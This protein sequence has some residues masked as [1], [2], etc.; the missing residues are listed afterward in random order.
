LKNTGYVLKLIARWAIFTF[1]ISVLLF[2]TAGTTRLPSLRNYLATF[3]A[4]LLATMLAI[5]PGLAKERSSTFENGGPPPGRFAAGLSFL[6]TLVFAALDVGR[7]EWF[8]SVPVDVRRT[9]LL[10]FAGAMALQMWAMIVNPFFSPEIR[11]QPECDHRLVACGPYRLL[12]HPGY[13]AM[14][15]AVPATALAIGS[16]LAL[17]PATA[18]CL[19]IVKRVGLE[20]EFLQRNLPGYTEYMT[21]VRGRLIPGID[22]R[23]PT[24]RNAV[25]SD[26]ASQDNRG[27]P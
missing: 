17:V 1:S 27:W 24:C 25:S 9:S 3:S 19:V 8:H 18:F 2:G 6:A 26:F 7:L 11:L 15:V 5:D 23:R 13:L 21:R 14:L 20:E 10:L 22:F 16:W 12:R 4:F